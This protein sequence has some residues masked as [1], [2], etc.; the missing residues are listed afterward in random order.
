MNWQF[1]KKKKDESELVTKAADTVKAAS[2]EAA[3]F[4]SNN[5]KL[6]STIKRLK[7][8]LQ[9]QCASEEMWRRKFNEIKNQNKALEA[10]IILLE[11]KVSFFKR[12]FKDA[13]KSL[14]LDVTD[15]EIKL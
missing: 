13:S 8:E 5:I 7:K 12:A 9:E 3:R 14:D 11:K 4:R 15:K 2:T 1:W 10:K 6:K